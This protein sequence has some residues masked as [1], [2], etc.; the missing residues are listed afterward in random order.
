MGTDRPTGIYAFMDEYAV[1]LLG[2]RTRLGIRVP[3]EVALVTGPLLS[4][5]TELLWLLDFTLVGQLEHLLERCRFPRPFIFTKYVVSSK[6]AQLLLFLSW[7]WELTRASQ[8]EHLLE[9]CCLLR[10]FIFT[11]NATSGT[12]AVYLIGFARLPP[13]Y[14]NSHYNLGRNPNIR[15]TRRPFQIVGAIILNKRLTR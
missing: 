15:H 8:L 9:R 5:E 6:K 10:A 2:A 13:G 4:E 14:T 3:Q 12:K 11:K 1:V 7:L